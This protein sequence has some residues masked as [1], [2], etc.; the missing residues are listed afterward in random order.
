MSI[1]KVVQEELLDFF[2]S[3]FLFKYIYSYTYKHDLK[4]GV[5]NVFSDQILYLESETRSR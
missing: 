2:L 1:I 5:V 3:D 4:I